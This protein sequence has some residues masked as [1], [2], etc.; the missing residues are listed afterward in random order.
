M[1]RSLTSD[2]AARLRAHVPRRFAA[3]GAPWWGPPDEAGLPDRAA[4]VEELALLVAAGQP[5]HDA[6]AILQADRPAQLAVPAARLDA[7]GTVSD[8][9]RAWARACGCGDLGMLAVE[10]HRAVSTD[11]VMGALDDAAATL[12]HGADEAL[13]ATAAWRARVVVVAATAA[14]AASTLLVMS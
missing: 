2:L 8:A 14:T 5:V 3:G 4:V 12:R 9:V 1:S 7:G 13:A 11:Q 10:L 6:I